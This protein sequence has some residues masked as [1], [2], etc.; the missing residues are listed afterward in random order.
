MFSID[1]LFASTTQ[2]QHALEIGRQGELYSY[3][4][5]NSAALDRYTSA[6]NILVPLLPKEPPGHRKELLQKQVMEW[7]REAE[8]IKA[9]V[10]AHDAT[11]NKSNH[12]HCCIQ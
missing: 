11:E 7:M 8:S 9:L 6:L 4:Q 12:Q 3:E 1:G 10:M 5:N 2:V